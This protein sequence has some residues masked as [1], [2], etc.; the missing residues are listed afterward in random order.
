[1]GLDD[2]SALAV[3]YCNH[4]GRTIAIAGRWNGHASNDEPIAPLKDLDEAVLKS[5][6]A[7][8]A[9]DLWAA[10]TIDPS[11]R[12]ASLV[13]RCIPGG[14]VWAAGFEGIGTDA[15]PRLERLS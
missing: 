9:E 3:G 5:V 6:D 13:V 7:S 14:G 15:T 2:G 1:M 10:G 11:T 4:G 8:S 12:P